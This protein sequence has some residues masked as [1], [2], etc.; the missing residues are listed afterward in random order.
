MRTWQER[1]LPIPVL[2]QRRVQWAVLSP[3]ARTLCVSSATLSRGRSSGSDRTGAILRRKVEPEGDKNER[4]WW[5][6]S[7]G[8]GEK[9]ASELQPACQNVWDPRTH[10]PW[11]W[12]NSCWGERTGWRWWWWR[13]RRRRGEWKL[14]KHSMSVAGWRTATSPDVGFF[15]GSCRIC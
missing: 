15:S 13:R 4:R 2:L 3:A 12:P 14:D 7:G 8:G 6:W 10:H 1:S 11:L 5:W 9:T